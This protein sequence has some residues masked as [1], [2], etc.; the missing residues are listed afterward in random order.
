MFQQISP[1]A[2]LLIVHYNAPIS[3]GLKMSC[4]NTLVEDSVKCVKGWQ[5]RSKLSDKHALYRDAFA[6]FLFEF[7]TF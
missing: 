1:G 6:D 5:K 4:H 7:E 3:E 2:G